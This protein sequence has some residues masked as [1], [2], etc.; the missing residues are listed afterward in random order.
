MAQKI[1]ITAKQ[2]TR[3]ADLLFNFTNLDFGNATGSYLNTF[4][5]FNDTTSSIPN[6]IKYNVATTDILAGTLKTSFDEDFDSVGVPYISNRVANVVTYLLGNNGSVDYF[7]YLGADFVDTDLWSITREDYTFPPDPTPIIQDTKII[8]SRSPYFFKATPT[9]LYDTMSLD[10]YVY[11]G[12]KVDDIPLLPTFQ[13]SKSVIQA[14]QPVISI[15]IHKLVNDFVQNDFT[16]NVS[17]GVQTT[18]QLDSVWVYIN[19]SIYLDGVV[20]NTIEE[21]ILAVDGF[22]YHQELANPIIDRNVLTTINNHI[23]YNNSKY[24]LYFISKDLISINING[25]NVP[26]TLDENYN[27]Q[28]IGYVDVTQYAGS[29]TNF[30]SIFK[31]D[32]ETITHSFTMQN[33]C[34]NELINC[35]F[36][37]KYGFWQKIGFNKLNR[38][39]LDITSDD[40]NP[41]IS[42]FGTYKLNQHTKR[43]FLTNGN[44]KIVVNTDFLPEY[45]NLLFKEL[46]LSEQVYLE[47]ENTI[48]PVNLNKK[49]LAYKTKINDKLIQYSMDFEYSFKTI[50]NIV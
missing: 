2:V 38:L 37:N 43:S 44:E 46:M 35:I 12:H 19:A 17:S 30:N 5:E 22:G 27:N 32:T 39:N 24:P 41:F 26:L 7:D 23:I 16:Q 4:R 31:Y 45:Y 18:N 50:N 34:R 47:Q 11:R 42:D 3:P 8:L 9:V 15:D 13:A 48:L 20:L 29:S 10:V 1:T 21:T 25:V 6:L 49:S 28:Y 33:E 14:G 36:K 40:Y